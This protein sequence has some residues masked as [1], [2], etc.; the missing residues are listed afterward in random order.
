M[1][2]GTSWLYHL[3]SASSGYFTPPVKEWHYLNFPS[4]H[5]EASAEAVLTEARCDWY[6]TYYFRSALASFWRQQDAAVGK[7]PDPDARERL[8]WWRLYLFDERN[9]GHVRA[10]DCTNRP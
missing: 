3:F 9:M 4:Q 1:K 2:A 5:G 10:I 7:M 8:A 6:R